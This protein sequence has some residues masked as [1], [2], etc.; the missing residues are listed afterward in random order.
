MGSQPRNSGHRDGIDEK[1]LLDNYAKDWQAIKA[2]IVSMGKKSNEELRES[3]ATLTGLVQQMQSKNAQQAALEL[4][5]VEVKN[6]IECLKKL[7]SHLAARVKSSTHMEDSLQ[8]ACDSLN[9]K[10][11][12]Q[13]V[14]AGESFEGEFTDSLNEVMRLFELQTIDRSE[15][16]RQ[17]VKTCAEIDKKIVQAMDRVN[18]LRQ[19]AQQKQR[20]IQRTDPFNVPTEA[21]EVIMTSAAEV[22]SQ[23]SK[24][25]IEMRLEIRSAN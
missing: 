2:A 8:K 17:L 9:K 24:S 20:V 25:L 7:E 19:A 11:Q 1:K 14:V 22:K 3:E 13:L 5:Q 6:D 15:E 4:R 12:E 21:R 16:D 18:A 23:L 10:T